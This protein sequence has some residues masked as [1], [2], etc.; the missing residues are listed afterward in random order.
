MTPLNLWEE[1][2]GLNEIIRLSLPWKWFLT[3]NKYMLWGIIY[4]TLPVL[5]IYNRDGW[6]LF[7]LFLQTS[8]LSANTEIQHLRVDRMNLKNRFF[9]K[10]ISWKTIKDASEVNSKTL[11]SMNL[12]SSSWYKTNEHIIQFCSFVIVCEALKENK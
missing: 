6:V 9:Q 2:P 1:H 7:E 10:T 12:A 4:F 8:R 3:T 11:Q 5:S